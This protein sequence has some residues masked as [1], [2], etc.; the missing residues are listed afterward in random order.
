MVS[1]AAA[2]LFVPLQ[3]EVGYSYLKTEKEGKEATKEGVDGIPD[4]KVVLWEK[5]GG[6][7]E[8]EKLSAPRG[9]LK[10]ILKIKP[11]NTPVGKGSLPHSGDGSVPYLSLSYAQTWL[12]HATRAILFSGNDDGPK[13]PLSRIEI[14]H[15]P[16]GAT[17][18]EQGPRPKLTTI[19]GEKKVE[20]S[21]DTGT[22]H[23]H[24]TR[25]KP[26]MVKYSSHG[27][28]RTTGNNYTTTVIEAIGVE[29]KE[30]TR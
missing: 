25:Y 9:G 22:A 4:L 14:S 3:T 11:Q 5:A 29:H 30:T 27:T 10:D 17:E 16:K 24:G 2:D 7:L 20:E 12:L 6:F 15:R 19:L 18:W 26:E 28:S 23:P 1:D 13:N 21:S 8:K